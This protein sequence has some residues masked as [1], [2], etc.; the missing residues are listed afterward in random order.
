MDVTTHYDRLDDQITG[1]ICYNPQ[2]KSDYRTN[3]T[4]QISRQTSVPTDIE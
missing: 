1:R 4:T 2:G 3:P